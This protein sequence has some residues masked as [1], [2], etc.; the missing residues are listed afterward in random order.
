MKHTKVATSRDIAAERLPSGVSRKT[1]K[2][3]TAAHMPPRRVSLRFMKPPSN[4]VVRR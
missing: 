1:N 2:V 3:A 4:S